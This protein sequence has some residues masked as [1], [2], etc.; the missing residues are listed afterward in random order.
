LHNQALIGQGHQTLLVAALPQS[1]KEQ[2]VDLSFELTGRP[3]V[4]DR[5][6]LIKGPDVLPF[7]PQKRAVMRPGQRRMERA[8]LPRRCFGGLVTRCVT[9]SLR[10]LDLAVFRFNT[11]CVLNLRQLRK[12]SCSGFT[13]RRVL[14][15]Q[16]SW[17]GQ[18]EGAHIL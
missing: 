14:F 13:T 6:D 9:C 12:P 15:V 18:I 10:W 5:F 11:H 7:H 17:I 3:S 1:L 16:K 4:L 2:G 8:R